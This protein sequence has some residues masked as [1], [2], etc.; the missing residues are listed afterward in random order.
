M[1]YYGYTYDLYIKVHPKQNA[2]TFSGLKLWYAP[3][4]HLN[5]NVKYF[6][7]HY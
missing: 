1:A 5:I 7:D 4:Y 6:R 2:E 3:N